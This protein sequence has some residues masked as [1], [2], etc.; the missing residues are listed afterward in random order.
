M[1]IPL[2]ISAQPLC[3]WLQMCKASIFSLGA[4]GQ[5]V[6][7]HQMKPNR[8]NHGFIGSPYIDQA[9]GSTPN[10]PYLKRVVGS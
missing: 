9:V 6:G 1:R 10:V 7:R 4:A 8:F 3:C 5:S 2:A